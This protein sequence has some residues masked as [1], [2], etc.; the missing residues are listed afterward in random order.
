MKRHNVILESN[1]EPKDNN[2]LW[3]QGNK[4]KKFGNTG[5]ED[6]TDTEALNQ[7]L[8]TLEEHSDRLENLADNE[9]IT[10]VNDVLK[11]ANKDYSPTSYSGLGR[12]YLRKN[13]VDGK[14][15]LTQDMINQ[16][17]TIYIIQYDYDINGQ[18]LTIPSGCVLQ[19]DGGS[20]SNGTLS[21]QNSIL[22][23]NASY[24]FKEGLT[25]SGTW[26]NLI[27]HPENFGVV[28]GVDTDNVTKFQR[29][30]DNT[31]D[32]ATVKFGSNQVYYFNYR[33]GSEVQTN[34]TRMVFFQKNNI[35]IDGCGCTINM[36]GY[37]IEELNSQQDPGNGSGRDIFTFIQ[38]LNCDNCRVHDFNGIGDF[39][40]FSGKLI[41][42]TTSCNPRG[43]FIGIMAS[44]NIYV[45]R[46]KATNI[47]GNAVHA[48]PG[49]S[50]DHPEGEPATHAPCRNISV[51]DCRVSGCLEGGINFQGNTFDCSIRN[52]TIDKCQ[53]GI[54][55]GTLNSIIEGNNIYD[56][57]IGVSC[58]S[59]DVSVM[60]NHIHDL[61]QDPEVITGQG[62]IYL[63]GRASGYKDGLVTITGNVLSNIPNFALLITGGNRNIVINGNVMRNIC[64]TPIS[65]YRFGNFFM[66]TV[67]AN[68]ANVTYTNNI[69]I[70]SPTVTS[71]EGNVTQ[72][73]INYWRYC[74]N[75]YIDNNIIVDEN[76]QPIT[77]SYANY[78][79]NN[80]PSTN[81]LG[82]NV[83][84]HYEAEATPEKDSIKIVRSGGIYSALINGLP[85]LGV[86]FNTG[87]SEV[88][89]IVLENIGDYAEFKVHLFGTPT[90]FVSIPASY[91]S[92]YMGCNSTGNIFVFRLKGTSSALLSINYTNATASPHVIKVLCSSISEGNYTYKVYIDDVE[93]GEQ[94]INSPCT[95][96]RIGHAESSQMLLYSMKT[97]INSI[98]KTYTNTEIVEATAGGTVYET[99]PEG[100]SKYDT[101]LGKMVVWNGSAWINVDG[102]A[103]E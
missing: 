1:V 58:D 60:S 62:A 28:A 36:K 97:Y 78:F 74:N 30:A 2:V 34:P 38:L 66:G 59:R 64:H 72:L 24:I 8:N 42:T 92:G 9:D 82:N 102:T 80:Y 39:V 95:F 79:D 94:T 22:V 103:L 26:I 19:V 27:L 86:R 49:G 13:F 11:F 55:T 76:N 70:T 73:F 88:S 53:D 71:K 101:T 75:V 46:I 96:S 5:W 47:I 17:N 37:S 3:L 29:L 61:R 7:A 41:F 54:E 98:S 45:E 99:Y 84:E 15:V 89:P 14:N 67:S 12:V 21:G 32:G 16:E 31:P 51:S 57:Y 68:V 48:T 77:G 23:E 63:S 69:I 52:C 43:K 44:K 87:Y 10:S 83:D 4:L 90:Y 40:P 93:K 50:N 25:L 81:V 6:I 35:D 100:T 33:E 20:F 91:N 18:S 85:S 65:A 56:C